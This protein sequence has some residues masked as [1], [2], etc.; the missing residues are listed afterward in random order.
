MLPN[1]C[2]K[3]AMPAK[4]RFDYVEWRERGARI[5]A[6][7]REV[8]LMARCVD[9]PGYRLLEQSELAEVNPERLKRLREEQFSVANGYHRHVMEQP[10]AACGSYDADIRSDPAHVGKTRGAGAKSDR[11]LPLCRDC[12]LWEHA[13]PGEFEA[14]FF[15]R[16]GVTPDEM[17]MARHE[18][19]HRLYANQSSP[20]RTEYNPASLSAETVAG[21]G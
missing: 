6:E 17:A 5:Y 7:R 2:P 1:A 4:R 14:A 16:H 19:Y 8:E 11:V 3:P 15:D 20:E 13:E 21:G 12:H 18:E 10:C 9:D